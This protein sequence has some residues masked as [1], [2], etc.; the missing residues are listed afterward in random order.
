M[1]L[2]L[3]L[4]I[5][6]IFL[7]IIQIK[8]E[9][10]LKGK[11]ICSED[12]SMNIKYAFDNRLETQFEVKNES[13]GWI[14]LNL[15]GSFHITKIEWGINN[16]DHNDY[17]LGIFEGA[18]EKSFADA[19]PLYMITEQT[20][21]NTMNT[22]NIEY[23]GTFGF[24]RY[25][26]PSGSHCKINNI[27]IYG[28]ESNSKDNTGYYKPTNL[29]LMVIHSFTGSETSSESDKVKAYFYIIDN[30][31]IESKKMNGELTL[32]GTEDF[33]LYKKS[34]YIKFS[35]AQKP[36]NFSRESQNW[37]LFGNY[38]DKTLLRNLISYNISE[39]MGMV[40]TVECTPI[41]LMVNGEYKGTY[42]LCE[43]IEVSEK[44]LNITKM[45][46]ND[47]NGTEIS[48]GY[49]LEINGFA[50]LG[51]LH[52][53]S[54]KGIPIYIKYPELITSQQKAYITDKFDELEMELYE[55]NLSKIDI[56]NFVKYFLFEELIG[57]DM[58]YWST[59]IYKNRDSDLFYFGLAWDNDMAFD[60]D[61][62]AY[63]VS[64]KNNFAFNFGVAA[65]S[66]DKLV[67]QILKNTEVIN[68]IK[69]SFKEI[70]DNNIIDLEKLNSFIDEKVEL[71]AQSR[72]LNFMRWKILDKLVESNPKVYNSYEE[73]ISVI[74]DFINNRITWLK[75]FILD[76]KCEG[77][78]KCVE[79][80]TSTNETKELDYEMENDTSEGNYSYS[81]SH[82]T[83][84]IL[85]IFAILIFILF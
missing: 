29:P 49:L 68:E 12:N 28:E 5:L 70:I 39:M 41:D 78:I 31:N 47:N 38:G 82:K 84:N 55:N 6:F 43:K 2:N 45:T 25:V 36:L 52:F 11:I 51:T 10:L 59:Y 4:F 64:C 37:A 60:N 42:N 21:M 67:N 61:K 18:N 9:N 79:Q 34:Y 81:L 20:K 80:T 58:A 23:Q 75:D 14:G 46:E 35:E 44:K 77:C 33:N 27:K 53:N 48:G 65:G 62:R 26:G 73:E 17:L 63:Q 19:I 8:S 66:M 85:N 1:K 16:A 30:K 83:I 24:I 57:N 76:I 74:K 7:F 22:I 50:Y 15:R 54:K 13:Y 40:Y 3:L 71:I 56:K 72:K 69:K 32:K